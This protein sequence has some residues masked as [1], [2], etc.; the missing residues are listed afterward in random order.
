MQKLAKD[1]YVESGFA[2]VTVGAV[3]TAEGIVCIDAPTHAADA[4]RWRLKL[5]QLSEA[6]IQFVINLDHHRDRVV[7]SQWFEAPVIAHEATSDR[8]RQLPELFKGGPSEGGADA[9]LAPDLA[10][11]R[12]VVPL[13][14]LSERVE[15]AVGGHALHLVRRPG[16]AP[17]AIWVELPAE[18][19]VFTGD[20][21]TLNAPPPM[22]EVDL[23]AWLD[24]LAE[25]RKARFPAQVIVPGRGGPTDKKAVPAMQEFIR[26]ARRKLQSLA[27]TRKPRTE[28]GPLADDLIERFHVTHALREHYT[29]RLRAG[30]EHLYDQMIAAPAA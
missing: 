4:R 6:P 28:V 14:S 16:S 17:G 3:V 29:R 15:L 10:G 12:F 1:I 11:V 8:L 26:Q 19:I 24:S 7:G 30:L 20:A 22:Q 5:A 27:R 13:L 18:K 23:D 21:L 25:L 2:G 9:D